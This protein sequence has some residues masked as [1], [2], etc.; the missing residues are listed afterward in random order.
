MPARQI[1]AA[2][3]R[4]T[5]SIQQRAPGQDARGQPTGA[6]AD[7]HAGVLAE[8]APV[9]GREYFAAGQLQNPTDTRITIRHRPG[10]VPSMRVLHNG[11]PLDIISVID[12]DSRGLTLEL[13]CTTTL[14][15]ARA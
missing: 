15:D 8:V 5:I 11:Q 13:M 3:L 10:I 9:R 7:V 1:S 6:W 12:P 2:R 14:R 4:H